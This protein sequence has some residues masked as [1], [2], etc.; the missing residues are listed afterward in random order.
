MLRAVALALAQ[1]FTGPILGVL[2]ACVMLSAAVFVGLWAGIDWLLQHWLAGTWA[3]DWLLSVL[4]GVTT[5]VL[6]WLLF[7][8]VA[9]SFVGLFLE[10][11]A[12]LVERRHYPSLPKAHGLSFAAG[13]G[14]SLRFLIVLLGANVL[15]LVL[16]LFPP[17]YA[18]AWFVVNG[19]LIGREYFELVAMRRLNATEADA[20]RK[21]HRV[22]CLV[23]GAALAAL[24]TLPVVNLIL[25]VLA[26][27]V[28]VHRY[29]AWQPVE[30][31]Y[32][33]GG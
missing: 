26:T 13:V 8:L 12:T 19:W 29:H 33:A 5:L 27:A 24:S 18:V 2:G 7:P 30:A 21:R 23:T 20:L 17:V 14:V 9:S 1:L 10:R 16:L 3:A 25:P 11:V 32:S 28:M 4:G 6:A 15:L 22:E 31:R